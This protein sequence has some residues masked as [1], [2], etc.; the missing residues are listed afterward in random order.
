LTNYITVTTPSPASKLV[1]AYGFEEGSGTRVLDAS[2][3][4]NAGALTNTA[5]STAGRF[6]KALTFNGNGWITI[7]DAASLNLSNAL[8]L[9]AWVYPTAA[10]TRWTDILMKE[11][12]GGTSYYLTAGSPSGTPATGVDIGAERILRGSSP[13]PLNTWSHVAASYD[14]STL[15]L[16]VNGV[17]VASTPQAG[18][19]D[20]AP[21]PLRIGGNS[22]WGEYFTGRI[23]EVRIYSRAL[24]AA[25]IQADMAKPVGPGK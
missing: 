23:D 25:E 17:L 11:K 18:S 7:N 9:E 22:V 16:Y 2:G 12:A 13:L 6:G 19:I 8:T 4:A 10:L 24:S 15:R 3:Y 21:G 5:W 1:A 14:G 20:P